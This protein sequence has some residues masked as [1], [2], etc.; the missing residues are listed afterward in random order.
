MVFFPF[1]QSILGILLETAIWHHGSSS[2]MTSSFTRSG[3]SVTGC[4]TC[5]RGF[6]SRKQK[7]WVSGPQV[8]QKQ[9]TKGMALHV[10]QRSQDFHRFPGGLVLAVWWHTSP[11]LQKWGPTRTGRYPQITHFKKMFPYRPSI[12]GYP[13]LWKP[14]NEA[15][16]HWILGVSQ[17]RKTWRSTSKRL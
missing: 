15:L 13:H 7:V 11:G 3:T 12:L 4:S 17:F 9:L 14:P 16:K 5:S 1:K 6:S 2:D 8:I 10:P